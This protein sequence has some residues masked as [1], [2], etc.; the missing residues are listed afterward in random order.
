MV[1]VYQKSIPGT[2]E[3]DP[4]DRRVG[5]E[6]RIRPYRQGV[7]WFGKGPG[8]L[9]VDL[10]DLGRLGLGPLVHRHPSDEAEVEG[11]LIVGQFICPVCI[12]V[13]AVAGSGQFLI[14]QICFSFD[15]RVAVRR[16]SNTPLIRSHRPFG[17]GGRFCIKKAPVPEGGT[18]AAVSANPYWIRNPGSWPGLRQ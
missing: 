12:G 8:G 3:N 11:L 7:S 1:K 13:E 15:V 10:P 16:N 5:A 4:R 9:D 18:G 14:I 6:V 17:G 2:I